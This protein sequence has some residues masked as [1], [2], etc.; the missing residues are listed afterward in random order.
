MSAIAPTGLLTLIIG[1]VLA[2]L[3]VVILISIAYCARSPTK[4]GGHSQPLRTSSFQRLQTH[5]SA[6]PCSIVF[7]PAP[8]STLPRSER[9]NERLP[10][11]PS[12]AN[13]L[14]IRRCKVRLSDLLQEGTFGKVYRGT[15]EGQNVLVKTVSQHANETQVAL[16]LKEGTSLF[17]ASHPGILGFLGISIDDLQTPFVLYAASKGTTN[18]KLFLHEPSSRALTTIQI[19]MMSYQLA[20]ALGHLHSHAVVHKDVAAR[21]C[22]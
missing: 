11:P 2:L 8:P 20:L 4:R 14:H 16:L 1:S 22:V 18:L 19:V 9:I 5:P 15:Y 6:P 12:D 13:D 17:A 21:N 3:L 10:P 7:P